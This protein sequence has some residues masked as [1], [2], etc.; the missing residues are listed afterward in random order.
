[1]LNGWVGL[2]LGGGG[3]KWVEIEI[4][5]GHDPSKF[6]LGSNDLKFGL[7]HMTPSI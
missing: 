2:K 3:I 1:M 6:T 7:G 5:L 4:G